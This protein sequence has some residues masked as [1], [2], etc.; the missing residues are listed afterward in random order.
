M[1]L[2]EMYFFP[3]DCGSKTSYN[4]V[5][6]DLDSSVQRSSHRLRNDFVPVCIHSVCFHKKRSNDFSDLLS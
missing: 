1:S 2:L 3:H 4:F 6:S 5:K